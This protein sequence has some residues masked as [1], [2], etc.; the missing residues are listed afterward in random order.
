MKHDGG[1][2]LKWLLI[3]IVEKETRKWPLVKCAQRREELPI[4]RHVGPSPPAPNSALR[5]CSSNAA[6]DKGPGVFGW[7]SFWALWIPVPSHLEYGDG[8]SHLRRVL[9]GI[10]WVNKV[11]KGIQ[12]NY[13]FATLPLRPTRSTRSSLTTSYKWHLFC[14]ILKPAVPRV[15]SDAHL[16][17]CPQQSQLNNPQC[18]SLLLS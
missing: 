16:T 3:T 9:W 14:L 15:T 13:V 17:A 4:P 8:S 12:G 5:Y 2:R 18:V 1:L 11:L 6:T 7:V 10:H